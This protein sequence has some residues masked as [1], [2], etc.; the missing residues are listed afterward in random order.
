MAIWN[1]RI[2]DGECCLDRL[3]GPLG[4]MLVAATIP[5]AMPAVGEQPCANPRYA[6]G[7]SH[8]LPLQYDSD[9]THFAYTNPD[10]PKAGDVR[11]AVLGTFDNY[12]GIIEKGRLAAGYDATGGLVY[13]RLLEP[14]IDE[15]VSYYGRLAEGVVVGPDFAWVAFKLRADATWHDGA[16]ITVE[17]VL[18]TY[19]AM[20]EHGSVALRTALADLDHVFAFGDGELCFVRKRG[21]EINPT[22]PFTLSSFSILPKHYWSDRDI[23]K[24][25]VQAP[26]GSGPYRLSRAEIGRLLVYERHENYWGRDI[27]VNKGR[28]NFQRVKFDHFADE[29][30]MIEA[31]KGNVID[32]RQEGVSKNWATQYN[33]PAVKAGLFRRELRPLARVEGLWWP[34]FWNVDQPHLRDVRIREALWLL[35]DFAWTNRVLFYGF[36]KPGVSFFQNSPMAHRGLP[37]EKELA[38]LEPWRD[39]VPPRVFTEEFR[40]PSSDGFGQERQNIKRALALFEEAGWRVRDGTMRNIETGEP[41]TLDFIGVSYYSIRQNLSL[42]GNLDRIGVETTGVSPEVSQWLYRSRTGK[43]DGNSVRLGPTFTPGLQLRNWFGSAAADHDYGQNWARVRNPVVDSLVQSI[44][45][46]DTAEDLYAATRALDRVLL[47]NFYF[48]P[49]G[50]QPGFRLVYWD[51]FSE[52]RNDA[53]TRVPYLDAWWWDEAKARRVEAGLA[54]LAAG[55]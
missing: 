1:T 25:T 9:F 8:L 48:I 19:E 21:A 32:I 34:I 11:V 28:Y 10:A 5:W 31:H 16:P 37:S 33:F 27:P 43:F 24:T 46:A 20:Q 4:W 49:V 17:D 3:R 35:F 50:S 15:P 18:F 53:L 39:Q 30:V 36:Y 55:G 13:D 2:V 22:F 51:K 14:A 6:H 7:I 52:V 38:L 54:E 47:W 40:Q 41:F 45:V 26:L 44:I 29:Q 12:N 42:I 23:E